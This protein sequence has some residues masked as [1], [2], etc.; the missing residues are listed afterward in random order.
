MVFI[1]SRDQE[2]REAELSHSRKCHRG[3]EERVIVSFEE[4]CFRLSTLMG[5]IGIH[6]VFLTCLETLP[7]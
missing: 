5:S 3:E 7:E 1:T 4:G 2:S 6:S